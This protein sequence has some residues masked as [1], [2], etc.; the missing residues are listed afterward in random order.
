[1]SEITRDIVGGV[2]LVMCVV[3]TPACG[4]DSELDP[5]L[6]VTAP[7]PAVTSGVAVE[8]AT[9]VAFT[10]GPTVDAE[11]TVYFTDLSNNRIMTL[12]PDGELSTFRQPSHRANGLIFDSEW[13]LL[14]CESGDGQSILP[15]VTRTQIDTGEI[16]DALLFSSAAP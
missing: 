12:S 14:A 15:R 10:E 4:S 6:L 5:T 1:M 11:G 16:E 8:V 7:P 2:A 3:L 9:T 13:R